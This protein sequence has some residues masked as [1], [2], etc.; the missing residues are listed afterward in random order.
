MTKCSAGNG[1]VKEMKEAK[2]VVLPEVR[3]IK[4]DVEKLKAETQGLKSA[5]SFLSDNAKLSRWEAEAAKKTAD[6]Y[7][8]EPEGILVKRYTSNGDG[9]FSATV[10][11][12]YSAFHYRNTTKFVGQQETWQAEAEK[13]TA[14]SY[15][16]EPH[17]VSVKKYTSNGDG[18][19][20]YAPTNTFSAR[21]YADEALA[22][23]GAVSWR[24]SKT[25]VAGQAVVG[26]DK[27][28]NNAS[29][30]KNGKLLEYGTDY[31]TIL[32]DITITPAG[33]AG[34]V[35]TV[36]GQDAATGNEFQTLLNETKAVYSST[37]LRR[38]EAEAEK[39]T[40]DSYANEAVDTFVKK[41][42]S[43]GDGTFS[44]TNTSDRSAYHWSTKM[45]LALSNVTVVDLVG[46]LAV[47]NVNDATVVYVRG[48]N[49]VG[50]GGA[51]L[52]IFD[53]KQSSVN[54]G[55]TII[56]GW[57]RQY[58]GAVNVLWF[59]A[60]N[61]GI[62]VDNSVAI[63]KAIASMNNN[64][65]LFFPE[66][67]Y[68][69]TQSI[70][71]PLTKTQ[72]TLS[73]SG[74]GA[75]LKLTGAIVGIDREKPTNSSSVYTTQMIKIE[76]F[77][78]VGDSTPWQY[79]VR[80]FTTYSLQINQ[81]KVTQCY[82][83]IGLYFC[84]N[85]VISGSMTANNSYIGFAVLSGASL[86]NGAKALPGSNFNNTNS[87]GTTL[88]NCR[89][90]AL[91]GARASFLSEACDTLLFQSCISEGGSPVSNF[92]HSNQGSTVSIGNRYVD[93]H[94][95][96]HATGQCWLMGGTLSGHY[97]LDGMDNISAAPLLNVG[98]MAS[99]AIYSIINPR[100]IGNFRILGSKI[101]ANSPTFN[102]DSGLNLAY[103]QIFNV[104]N[105]AGGVI[106]R[107]IYSGFD[108]LNKYHN[109]LPSAFLNSVESE[110]EIN[111][112]S[113]I[114]GSLRKIKINSSWDIE[115]NPKTT[116]HNIFINGRLKVFGATKNLT[117]LG[118]VVG[119]YPIY[120]ING[121]LLGYLP[122]YNNIT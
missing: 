92:E 49:T 14:D 1:F 9:T 97:I 30:Y 8:N 15:A 82:I 19:F 10:E 69:L 89:D 66:G 81:V 35:I 98:D 80:M 4:G 2:T 65:V 50:D 36:V 21:H 64:G 94:I 12:R 24:Q 102:I 90:F 63:N 29:V 26:F 38:W 93:T 95:E 39:M 73:L 68:N 45:N 72:S 27:N 48:F 111:I 109:R 7:A 84:M 11:D 99:T 119:K 122:I 71:L 31:T 88:T 104:A 116:G 23:S 77:N 117:T 113:G 5:T 3:A 76:G 62:A 34:D 85:A 83:G 25:L 103:D 56:D 115:L 107:V 79:G 91:T 33:V 87:N 59:G 16:N 28:I 105:W 96:N 121:V 52:F 67:T 6:S 17:G 37:Q 46:D 22:T 55:G 54:N 20:S 13:M 112:N 106:G 53:A 61:K 51:G 118:S 40:A 60:E 108:N 74:Y 100:W 58:E 114:N 57:V 41:Y 44:V 110:G 101:T 18:T 47:I 42:T 86:I 32:K 75:T 120:D 70:I 43:N 78:I